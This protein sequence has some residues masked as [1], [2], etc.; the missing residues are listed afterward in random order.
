MFGVCLGLRGTGYGKSAS[1]LY[2]FSKLNGI[3]EEFVLRSLDISYCSEQL[4]K[5]TYGY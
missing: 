2:F 1:V 5:N 4:W 3:G